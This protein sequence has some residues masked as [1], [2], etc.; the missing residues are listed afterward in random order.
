MKK[1]PRYLVL[2]IETKVRELHAKLLMACVA[3]EAGFDVLLGGMINPTNIQSLPASIL[4]DKSVTGKRDTRFRYYRRMGHLVTAWD[5]EG[6]IYYDSIYRNRL[7]RKALLQTECFFCW[8]EDQAQFIRHI[9][10]EA[11]DKLAVSGNPRIDLL[12]PEFRGLFLAEVQ[13]W[14]EK[15]GPFILINTKFGASNHYDRKGEEMIESLKRTGTIVTQEQENFK[16]RQITYNGE[17]YCAF[18]EMVRLISK[19]FQTH[20]IILRP[21]PSE[22]HDA[23]RRH[24]AD[25]PNIVVT[26]E[27]NVIP[28]ILA[29]DAMVHNS[30]TTGLESFLLDKLSISY[31][32]FSSDEF[33]HYLP[34]ALSQEVTHVNEL[35]AVLTEAVTRSDFHES[36]VRLRSDI[37]HR[38]LAGLQ[39]SPLASEN[40]VRKLLTISPVDRDEHINQLQRT[41]MYLQ[42]VVKPAAKAVIK[43]IL[44]RRLPDYYITHKLPSLE[45]DE[46]NELLVRFQT[47]SNRFL[48][49][50]IEQFRPSMFHIY[51]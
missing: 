40:I 39:G 11:A 33:D 15:Y 6:L 21:H 31:R 51:T 22:N 18:V 32:P 30:C 24:V 42:E 12:R 48:D 43:R 36:G 26:H 3:A 29:A 17:M 25:L 23:W 38:Y 4:L 8:G 2:P 19:R 34:N 37:A 28:W 41:T 16:R 13:H 9:A 45:Y 49:V 50:K 7:S 46:L 14:R 1:T 44:S 47:I 27:G 10:P 35:L 20:T 5:E